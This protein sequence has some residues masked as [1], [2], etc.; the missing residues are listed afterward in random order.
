MPDVTPDVTIDRLTLHLSGW[1]EGDGRHLARLI[2]D[3]LAKAAMPDAVESR[4]SIEAAAGAG[5]TMQEI[6]DRVVADVLRQ[7]ERSV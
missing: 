7:L 2:A 5:G 4:A 3:G 6:A 1:S